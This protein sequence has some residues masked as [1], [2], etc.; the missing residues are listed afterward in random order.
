MKSQL[1]EMA[2]G[3]LTGEID[4]AAASVAGQLLNIKLRAIEQER[5][6]KETGDLEARIEALE[7]NQEGGRRWRA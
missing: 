5:K 4:R 6:S 3:V 2:N 1:Q 7:H